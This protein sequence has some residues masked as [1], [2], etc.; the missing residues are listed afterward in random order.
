MPKRGFL[1][2]LDGSRVRK[3]FRMDTSK[4]GHRQ[5]KTEYSNV[6][7]LTYNLDEGTVVIDWEGSSGVTTSETVR[8]IRAVLANDT[9]SYSG[10]R[11]RAELDPS[12]FV[13]FR[14][15]PAARVFHDPSKGELLIEEDVRGY[16]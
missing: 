8:N 14:F 9:Y 10:M 4:R 7:G 13:G 15:S 6:F 12:K 1:P 3:F 16:P 2:D 11:V 5:E